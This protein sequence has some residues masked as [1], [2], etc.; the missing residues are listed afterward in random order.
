M[1]VSTDEQS[2]PPAEK[3]VPSRV[4][5]PRALSQSLLIKQYAMII[6]NGDV[7]IDS[8]R[9][10]W[11]LRFDIDFQWSS[12]HVIQFCVAHPACWIVY[13][14]GLT[15]PLFMKAQSLHHIRY[16]SLTWHSAFGPVFPLEETA[17]APRDLLKKK[18][19]QARCSCKSRALLRGRNSFVTVRFALMI[20]NHNFCTVP[21]GKTEQRKDA[22]YQVN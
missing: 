3:P 1:S 14:I 20:L 19:I 8:F 2:V 11:S 9:K 6:W 21:F 5:P 13:R 12:S 7:P 4:P 18:A 16:R 22:K 10:E 17:S 15:T